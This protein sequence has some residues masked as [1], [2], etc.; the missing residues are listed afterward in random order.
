MMGAGAKLQGTGEGA[1]TAVSCE[2]LKVCSQDEGD[3]V[4]L[5]YRAKQVS[6]NRWHRPLCPDWGQFRASRLF[7]A[8]RHLWGHTEASRCNFMRFVVLLYS[9]AGEPDG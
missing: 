5:R 4:S 3:A 2:G 1:R 6:L 8:L 9:A 7:G